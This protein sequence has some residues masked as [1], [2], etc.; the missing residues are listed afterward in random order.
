MK[1]ILIILLFIRTNSLSAQM[2]EKDTVIDRVKYHYFSY[3]PDRKVKTLSQ[4]KTE[5]EK[6]EWMYFDNKGEEEY[7]G[8]FNNKGNKHG[9][10]W[11]RKREIT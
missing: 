5:K 7:R 10:W 6:G 9:Q 1:I 3:Y 4:K 8:A 2:I 11:Y